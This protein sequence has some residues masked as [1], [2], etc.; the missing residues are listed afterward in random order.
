MRLAYKRRSHAQ[1]LAPFVI[2][3]VRRAQDILCMLF[4]RVSL[5][6][7]AFPQAQGGSGH[8]HAQAVLRQAHASFDLPIHYSFKSK[9]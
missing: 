3:T 8:K 1:G 6:K 5:R 4:R 7:N 2:K 9:R